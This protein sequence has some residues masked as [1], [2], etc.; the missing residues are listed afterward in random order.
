MIGALLR[1][2]QPAEASLLRRALLA[3]ATSALAQGAAL[4]LLPMAF[5]SLFDAAAAAGQAPWRWAGAFAGFAL[6]CL[7]V[8]R[9]A[10]LAGYRAGAAAAQ[11]LNLRI[12]EQL[13]RLPLEWFVERR[14]AEL[15]RLVTH[16]VLQIMSTPAHLLQPMANALLTPLALLVA[17]FFYDRTMAVRVPGCRHRSIPCSTWVPSG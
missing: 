7:G 4:A 2:L 6:L 15:N 1:S 10:Q 8:R 5:A 13:V 17:L 9:H 3:M 16:T 12:G 14:S 11:S